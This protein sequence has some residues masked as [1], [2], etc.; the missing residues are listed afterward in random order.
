MKSRFSGPCD[1]MR[2][3]SSPLFELAG[4]LVR[5][6]HVARIIVNPNHTARC[7]RL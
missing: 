2:V 1:V 5:L 4:V 7:D 3:K 6:D